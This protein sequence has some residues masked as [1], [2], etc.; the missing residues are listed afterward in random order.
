MLRFTKREATDLMIALIMLSFCFAI[1]TVKIDIHKILSLLPIVVIGVASGT[2]LHEVGH[3]FMAMRYGYQSEFKLWPIGLLI[4]FATAFF[5]VSFAKKS[6]RI[7]LFSKTG[8]TPVEKN[9]GKRWF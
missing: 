8:Y 6:L 1:S 7:C 4:G 2:I 9:E 3:K 5:V